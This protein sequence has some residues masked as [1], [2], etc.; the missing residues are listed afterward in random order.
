M[1]K[2]LARDENFNRWKIRP[3]KIKISKDLWSTK[4][5]LILKGKQAACKKFNDTFYNEVPIVKSNRERISVMISD[6]DYDNISSDSQ[7]LP[8]D[9]NIS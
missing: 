1:I 5:I 3:T 8:F 7:K 6:G 9:C 2:C 4:I